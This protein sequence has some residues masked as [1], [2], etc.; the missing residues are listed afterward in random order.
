M[1]WWMFTASALAA[2]DFE[3][4][5]GALC[6]GP[7]AMPFEVVDG[8]R[9]VR[10]R[11]GGSEV[12]FRITLA[13]SGAGPSIPAS[14]AGESEPL[15]STLQISGI[16]VPIPDGARWQR[17]PSTSALTGRGA[18]HGELGAGFFS[19]FA[20]VCADPAGRIGVQVSGPTPRRVA[21]R[22]PVALILASRE[23]GARYPFAAVSWGTER[24]GVLVDPLAMG[25]ALEHTPLQW[26]N[27]RSEPIVPSGSLLDET[28]WSTAPP[29][30]WP[31]GETER[32]FGR[33]EH[34]GWSIGRVG[35]EAWSDRRV[36]VDYQRGLLWTDAP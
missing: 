28:W 26:L 29:D 19:R 21:G 31:D 35:A 5:F 2:S 9:Q 23:H 15:P 32:Q 27:Q 18:D 6:S 3:R 12:P 14:L 16:P 25:S 1:W 8:H 24:G 13:G 34:Q 11:L 22:E 17:S 7:D 4:A 33:L 10:V 30:A 36:V 20:L